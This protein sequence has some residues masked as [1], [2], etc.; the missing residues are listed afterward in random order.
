[1]AQ[2]CNLKFVRQREEDPEFQAS[3][4][5]RVRLYLKKQKDGKEG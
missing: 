3:L 2:A 4:G 5:Y 1:V